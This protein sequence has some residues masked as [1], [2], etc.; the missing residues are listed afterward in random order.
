MRG[1]EKEKREVVTM[2]ISMSEKIRSTVLRS[3]RST[4]LSSAAEMG[5]RRKPVFFSRMRMRE[6]K[7]PF[8]RDVCELVELL[9]DQ[10]EKPLLYQ[11]GSVRNFLVGLVLHVMYVYQMENKGVPSF[12]DVLR[13]LIERS[14]DFDI[15]LLEMKEFA[16]HIKIEEALSYD[17]RFEKKLW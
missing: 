15:L 17:N 14:G 16:P 1:T 12:S 4:T 5:S 3:R 9:V 8:M 7:N 6:S 2:V 10:D 11:M 13:V